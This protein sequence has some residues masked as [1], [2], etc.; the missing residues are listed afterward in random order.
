MM[1]DQKELEELD[2]YY[3]EQGAEFYDDEL[4]DDEISLAE[5]GFMSGY[6]AA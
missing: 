6:L 1:Q 5:E 2:V 4:T 3:N